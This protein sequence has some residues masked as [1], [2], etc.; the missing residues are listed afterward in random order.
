MEPVLSG[1]EAPAHSWIA[2]WE[3]LPRAV[4]PRLLGHLGFSLP[5]AC[6]TCRGLTSAAELGE[7]ICFRPRC[8][9]RG[10]KRVGDVKPMLIFVVVLD[11]WCHT[12]CLWTWILHHDLA[13]FELLQHSGLVGMMANPDFADQTY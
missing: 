1:E 10:H 6:A 13:G 7:G 4:L 11:A 12:Q 5:A 2:C 8:A 9:L 3:A